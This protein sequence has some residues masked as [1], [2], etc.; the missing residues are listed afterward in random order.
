VFAEDVST[1]RRRLWIRRPTHIKSESYARS[2]YEAARAE[3]RSATLCVLCAMRN[4]SACYGQ[5]HGDV[6]TAPPDQPVG[7]CLNVPVEVVGAVRSCLP[8]AGTYGES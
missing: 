1:H 6:A 2:L 4:E 3:G 5:L 7:L 8:F